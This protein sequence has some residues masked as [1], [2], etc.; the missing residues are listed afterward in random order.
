MQSLSVARGL[1]LNGLN[2]LSGLEELKGEKEWGALKHKA[3]RANIKRAQDEAEVAKDEAEELKL[4][5][6]QSRKT[7]EEEEI[8]ARAK[9]SR[10]SNSQTSLGLYLDS[11]GWGS[12]H[13]R[14]RL[15]RSYLRKKV[16][17]DLKPVAELLKMVNELD[18]SASEVEDE[19]DGEDDVGTPD[20]EME[21][22]Q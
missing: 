18:L 14:I 3:A 12:Y 13:Y 10:I 8:K 1:T 19:D 17:E 5:L 20:R 9:R 16:L 7:F 6:F 4:K 21:P 2:I 15:A 22:T 11:T